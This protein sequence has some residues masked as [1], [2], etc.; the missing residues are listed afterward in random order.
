MK[1]IHSLLQQ[2]LEYVERHE[3]AGPYKVPDF[4]KYSTD[5]INYHIKMCV[6]AGWLRN[7]RSNIGGR[8][9]HQYYT[10][11]GEL[12]WRGHQELERLRNGG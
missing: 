1:L 6:E 7:G 5:Q 8:G 3:E 4:S 10:E 12:T 9:V 2:I 11:L